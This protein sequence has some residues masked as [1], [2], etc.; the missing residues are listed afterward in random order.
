MKP[1]NLEEAKAGKPILANLCFDEWEDAIFLAV[2]P[3]SGKIVVELQGDGAVVKVGLAS[4]RMAPTKR[5]VW[6][7]ESVHAP[8]VVDDVA[9]HWI[10]W[11]F[12]SFA[13][14]NRCVNRSNDRRGP[15]SLEIE[16]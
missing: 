5:T 8:K 9:D 16:E 2:A 10:A 13:D 7:V 3:K 6:V 1:F 14:A 15:Y 12:E 4:L 11:T